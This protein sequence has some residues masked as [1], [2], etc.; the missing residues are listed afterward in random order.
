M[1]PEIL[2]L[3]SDQRGREMRAQAHQAR[4]ARSIR[5]T[6]RGRNRSDHA[7]EFVLPPIPDF[8]DGTFHT[9]G[10]GPAPVAQ[11]AA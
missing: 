11:R 8:V 6:R 10:T 3:M 4:L 7:D 1:H 9:E 2:R 5:F